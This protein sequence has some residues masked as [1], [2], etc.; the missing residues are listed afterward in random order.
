MI[1]C[2]LHSIFAIKSNDLK[3]CL[4][5]LSIIHAKKICFKKCSVKLIKSVSTALVKPIN[6]QK[7]STKTFIFSCS[8]SFYI[9][10]SVIALYIKQ[11]LE[12]L[13]SKDISIC[14]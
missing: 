11:L 7:R 1:L 6:I 8:I 5:Y 9:Y 4:D 12:S 14:W 2:I 13:K 3:D 10:S